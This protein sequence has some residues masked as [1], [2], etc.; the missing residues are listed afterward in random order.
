MIEE[1]MLD[2]IKKIQMI[3]EMMLEKIILEEIQ[4]IEEIIKKIQM[5]EEMY[6]NIIN[7]LA[8]S[9]EL[10]MNYMNLM[11]INIH[12]LQ[13]IHHHQMIFQNLFLHGERHINVMMMIMAH[14]LIKLMTCKKG[15]IILK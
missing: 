13:I 11:I 4:M 6:L 15:Y 7:L 12:H 14:F 3:E 5:I 1:M 2:I 8:R 9:Q 10:L